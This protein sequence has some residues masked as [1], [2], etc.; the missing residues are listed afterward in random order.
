MTY[1]VTPNLPFLLPWLRVILLVR[2]I[3]STTWDA[4]RWAEVRAILKDALK[5]QAQMRRRAWWK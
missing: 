2:Q 4:T 1:N 5:M 3:R